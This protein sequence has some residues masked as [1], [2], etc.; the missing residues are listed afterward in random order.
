MKKLLLGLILI[1]ALVGVVY[2]KSERAEEYRSRLTEEGFQAGLAEG[3]ELGAQVDSLNGLVKQKDSILAESVAVREE[4][5]AG[6]IDSLSQQVQAGEE[7]IADLN[8]QLASKASAAKVAA[9]NSSKTPDNK[10][11]EILTYYKK[12]VN[13][14]PEDLSAYERRIALSE[15]R[16]ETTKRFRISVSLLNS[17]RKE[18][19][20]EY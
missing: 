19:N 18:N 5:W 11:L 10:H 9:T 20:L 17:L 14:L 4:L 8:S 13:D 16:N 6:E 3:E 15:I 2:L 12:A 1:A 7:L